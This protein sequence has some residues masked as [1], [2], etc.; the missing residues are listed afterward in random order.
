MRTT[1]LSRLNK[2]EDALAPRPKRRQM[3]IW[4]DHSPGCVER[5][6][7]KRVQEGSA[8]PGDEVIAVGWRRC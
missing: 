3:F 8:E 7:A 4:D 6:F 5:E 2:I 1:A